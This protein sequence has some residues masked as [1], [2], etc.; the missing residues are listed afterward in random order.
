[1]DGVAVSP[2]LTE[3]VSGSPPVLGF[4]PLPQRRSSPPFRSPLLIE[5]VDHGDLH[6]LSLTTTRF[7]APL[8]LCWL[9]LCSLFDRV[10]GSRGQ[11][12]PVFSRPM[13]LFL[14]PFK[15]VVADDL[16]AFGFPCGFS[17]ACE[18]LISQEVLSSVNTPVAPLSS[19]SLLIVFL[20]RL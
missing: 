17:L 15:S 4:R 3:I 8:V 10:L 11:V 19:Y 1:M 2:L 16:P 13:G 9:F 14:P 7:R 12:F 5:V 6:G 20:K 18:C